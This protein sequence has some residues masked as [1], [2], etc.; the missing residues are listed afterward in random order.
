[1]L[2]MRLGS[3][4]VVVVHCHRVAAVALRGLEVE[5]LIIIAGIDD[6]DEQRWCRTTVLR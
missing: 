2:R 1:M 6:V 3:A 4:R 5:T